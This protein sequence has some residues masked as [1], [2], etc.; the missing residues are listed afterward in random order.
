[1]KL[2]YQQPRGS[3]C[4]FLKRRE[5]TRG[6]KERSAANKLTGPLPETL[7]KPIKKG[8]DD[9]S[10]DMIERYFWILEGATHAA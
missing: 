9:V 4:N 7:V 8:C 6:K 3:S 10:N 5:K 2:K 1:M